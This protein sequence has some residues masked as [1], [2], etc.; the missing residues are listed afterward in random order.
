[1]YGGRGGDGRIL[2]FGNVA[3]RQLY[4]NDAGLLVGLM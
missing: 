1:M 4:R 2:A 3:S